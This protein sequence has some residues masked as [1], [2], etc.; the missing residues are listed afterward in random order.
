[1]TQAS[2]KSSD[3]PARSPHLLVFGPG[4]SA[5]PFIKT[6][7]DAGW[8]VSATWRRPESVQTIEKLGATAIEFN[9][10]AVS[11]ADL[12]DVSHILVSVAPKSGTDPVLD[13]FGPWISSLENLRW[14]G[15]LSSTNV[16]GNHDGAWVDETSETLPSLDRGKRRL[17][18][19]QAWTAL[20]AQNGFAVHIFRLAGIYGPGRNAIRSVLDG[21]AK[22]VIKAG[23]VFGRIHRD[24]IASALWLAASSGLES[25]I[26]NLSDDL[27]SPPQDVIEEA[28]QL[29]GMPPPP[30]VSF[31]DAGLSPMGRSF[32]EENK[33]VRNQKA[34]DTLGWQL[35]YPDYH[36]AL[37]KLL[38]EETAGQAMAST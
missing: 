33:R 27:P 36:Q 25:T 28:A 34:K 19:E 7:L 18:A 6:A 35:A 29:L 10:K 17:A 9:L 11:Q 26:F 30:E 38:K 37:P 22:R 4:F 24:D 1:M 32:Y 12:A 14:V 23:Q 20:G 3:L 5:R 2:S 31:E 13:T 21:K 8:R 16:Y 15:Y